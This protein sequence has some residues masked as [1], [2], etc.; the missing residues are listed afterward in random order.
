MGNKEGVQ[1]QRARI[2]RQILTVMYERTT[3]IVTGYIS[4]ESDLCIVVYS[5]VNHLQAY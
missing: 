2:D 4:Q 1:L 5:I 3:S